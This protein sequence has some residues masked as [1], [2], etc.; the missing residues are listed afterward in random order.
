MGEKNDEFN[1]AEIS[2]GFILL[3]R[4]ILDSPI[5]GRDLH[6]VRFWMYLLLQARWQEEPTEVG[7][8]TIERGQFLKAFRKIQEECEWVENQRIRR[9]STSKI[10]RMV[11]WL[12]TRGCI[13]TKTTT[14]ASF[15]FNL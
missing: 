10:H 14:L 13:Y 11:S 1:R 5:W 6:H 7:G 12:E 9:W 2:G 3:A 4:T 8:I 15:S